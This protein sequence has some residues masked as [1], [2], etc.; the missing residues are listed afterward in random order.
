[1]E[2]R[3]RKNFGSPNTSFVVSSRSTK[4]VSKK[5]KDD[6]IK[7]IGKGTYG[8]IVSPPISSETQII[9]IDLP[10]TNHARDDIGKFFKDVDGDGLY[11][12][13]DELDM[14][15]MINDIDNDNTFTPRLKGALQVN[16][17][18]IQNNDFY[19]CM[20]F[21]KSNPPKIPPQVYEII[22]EN[23]G[24][25]C[26]KIYGNI[27][28]D[29]FLTYLKPL[30]HGFLILQHNGYVHRDV[31]PDNLLY[32]TGKFTL[33]DY[34]L[35]CNTN[36]L[37]HIKNYSILG[38]VYTPYPP[39]FLIAFIILD[40]KKS[41]KYNIDSN[42]GF[43]SILEHMITEMDDFGLFNTDY[44]HEKHPLVTDFK[45]FTDGIKEFCDA[46]LLQTKVSSLKYEDVFNHI[47][48]L[49]ADVY[50]LANIFSVVEKNILFKNDNQK[51]LFHK[52]VSYCG[53][54]NPNKRISMTQL[55]EMIDEYFESKSP[56]S[57]GGSRIKNKKKVND[58]K[59][60]TEKKQKKIVKNSKTKV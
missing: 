48:A 35:M 36:E 34:G 59:I 1:M 7:L 4:T 49:K 45:N 18:K 23:S 32:K 15:K 9:Q 38:S 12:Y 29:K 26:D 50:S 44:M 39:E 42:Y 11:A 8:C 10:Y 52:M 13:N 28:F 37:Y 17:R 5:Q 24:V 56:S 47:L 6:K 30:I 43:C 2:T 31:K 51:K 21:N 41:G 40:V 33:I 57:M 19:N 27:T 58:I 3:K 20:M 14:Y 54:Y 55:L 25:P 16:P 60:K 46:I 53:Q 22:L